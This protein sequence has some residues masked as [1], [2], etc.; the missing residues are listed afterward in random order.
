[1]RADVLRHETDSLEKK[2]QR[3]REREEARK[4]QVRVIPS[5]EPPPA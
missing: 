1:V 4:S 5:S 2:K 3:M